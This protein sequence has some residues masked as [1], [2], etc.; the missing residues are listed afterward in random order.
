MN[1]VES[2][3][4]LFRNIRHMEGKVKG[5]STSKVIRKIDGID[6]ELTK[7][8][9]LKSYVLQVMNSYTIK[10][11]NTLVTSYQTI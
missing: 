7:R 6:V 3:R 2:Q 1:H 8:M 9:Q 5:S 10:P 11:N 4:R